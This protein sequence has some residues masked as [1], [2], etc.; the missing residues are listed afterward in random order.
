MG[1][2]SDT[3]DWIDFPQG[4]VRYAGGSKGRDEPRID[5]FAVDIYGHTYYG[6]IRQLFLPDRNN[7][8]VEI[9]S[10]GWPK[11]DWFGTEPDP[12][13]CAAFTANELLDVQKLIGRVVPAWRKLAQRPF[14]LRESSRSHFMGDIFFRD[15]WA[16]I[17]A[18]EDASAGLER[19]LNASGQPTPQGH[20]NSH[21]RAFAQVLL[22]R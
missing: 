2:Y 14:V 4:R 20:S 15:G 9:V 18:D 22:A 6:E 1:E 17:K 13:Q 19:E 12:R 16:L 7:Y 3:F 10:F 5:T 21:T 8:N 11:G